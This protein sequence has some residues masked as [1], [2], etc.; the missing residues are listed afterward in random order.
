MN[1]ILQAQST[2]KSIRQYTT[3]PIG[4]RLYSATFHVH[5]GAHRLSFYSGYSIVQVPRNKDTVAKSFF[6]PS[7]VGQNGWN[8]AS[9]IPHHLRRP[10]SVEAVQFRTRIRELRRNAEHFHCG[11][12]QIAT[13]NGAK[14]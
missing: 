11:G 1:A 14:T 10:Y 8:A 2:H 7:Q 4:D 6:H 3:I 9:R 5:K 12:Q 13:F